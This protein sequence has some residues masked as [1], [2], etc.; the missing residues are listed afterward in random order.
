MKRILYY[1]DVV[2]Q[3]FHF[4]RRVQKIDLLSLLNFNTEESGTIQ[5]DTVVKLC[6]L[7]LS[8]PKESIV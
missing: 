3:S 5:I 2:T 7:I 4:L 8:H 1:V 6:L